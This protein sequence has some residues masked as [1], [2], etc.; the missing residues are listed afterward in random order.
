MKETK[1]G[2]GKYSSMSK[3]AYIAAVITPNNKKNKEKRL[4]K[5]TDTYWSKFEKNYWK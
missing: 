2:L 3:G 4:E 5:H 1:T